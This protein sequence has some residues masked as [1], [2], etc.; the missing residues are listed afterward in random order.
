MAL[1]QMFWGFFDYCAFP[2]KNCL[3]L[4]NRWVFDPP[5]P[6][7]LEFHLC[8]LQRSHRGSHRAF[9]SLI[10]LGS[11]LDF[12]FSFIWGSIRDLFLLQDQSG[13]DFSYPFFWGAQIAFSFSLFLLPLTIN[14]KCLHIRGDS[15]FLSIH[16]SSSIW[17]NNSLVFIFLFLTD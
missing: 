9:E 4:I 1:T 16:T 8:H 3:A 5:P 15:F 14:S 6:L 12:S 10:V 7:H 2:L 11:A 13:V 17:I